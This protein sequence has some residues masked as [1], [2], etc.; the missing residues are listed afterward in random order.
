[1]K[2]AVCTGL[3]I[4]LS[5][6]MVAPA[7]AYAGDQSLV[8]KLEVL[9]D[10]SSEVALLSYADSR[11]ALSIDDRFVFADDT[12]TVV[13]EDNSFS[14][15][16]IKNRVIEVSRSGFGNVAASVGADS[17]SF[18]DAVAA[19]MNGGEGGNAISYEPVAESDTLLVS[20]A[21]SLVRV[22]ADDSYYVAQ[23]EYDIN[24]PSGGYVDYL[25][26]SDGSENCLVVYDGSGIAVGGIKLAG[27]YVADEEVEAVVTFSIEGSQVA[28]CIALP[29]ALLGA[30]DEVD[31]SVRSTM[32]A[33]DY[34]HFF[35]SSYWVGR[36][37]AAPYGLSLQINPKFNAQWD[38]RQQAWN[39]LIARH[40][41]DADGPWP[42]E[43][44]WRPYIKNETQVASLR[45]QFLC[46]TMV[47]E[48]K[49]PWNIEPLRPNVGLNA[50][51]AALCNPA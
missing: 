14:L 6:T 35:S 11:D 34:N 25:D 13:A 23:T 41:N 40:R 10:S 1:M 38:F 37:S 5:L 9:D 15:S 8:N 17:N 33:L 43:P 36:P 26:S 2:K 44:V 3:G 7:V 18:L 20:N 45:D 32:A 19:A 12:V 47:G 39:V 46:H 22:E 42:Q 48:M 50:C 30:E 51:I 31:A 49:A 29:A 4:A 21:V 16:P 28:V 24:V 27:L